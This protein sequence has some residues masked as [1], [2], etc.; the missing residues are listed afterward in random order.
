MKLLEIFTGQEIQTLQKI[1]IHR[2]ETIEELVRTDK[3]GVEEMRSRQ[4]RQ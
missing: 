1:M 2:F 3:E 4:K